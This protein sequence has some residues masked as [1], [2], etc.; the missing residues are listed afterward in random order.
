MKMLPQIVLTRIGCLVSFTLLAGMAGLA[1]AEPAQSPTP[2]GGLASTASATVSFSQGIRDVLK[3]LD[4]KVDASI[5]EAYI[6]SSSIA[7][8]PSASEI[9]ALKQ[10]GV[11]DEVI[12][13]VLQRGA[14]VRAQLAMGAQATA[15]PA[16]PANPGPPMGNGYGAASPYPDYSGY[17]DAYPYGDYGY[18]YPYY[19]SAYFGYPYSYWWYNNWY[20]W[21]FYSPFYHG[22]YGH[23]YYW[24]RYGYRGHRGYFPG[25]SFAFRGGFGNRSM[26]W[27]PARTGFGVRAGGSFGG[28]SFA[29]AGARSGGFGGA[30]PGGFGG[31][32]GGGGFAV[33][34]GGGFAGHGGGGFG[35]HGGG[36]R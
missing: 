26:A 15:P 24:D 21:A 33:H 23:R 3:M 7:F 6:K 1:G 32:H 30:R 10:R 13:T 36:H 12:T 9:I 11:P 34:G 25:R 19:G 4:A 31:W 27:S 5:V 29:F 28:R 18:G 20:P 17:A 8:N 35:G 22:Y 16:P 2:G 14:E